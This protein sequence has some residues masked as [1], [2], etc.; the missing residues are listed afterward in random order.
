[1]DLLATKKDRNA[2]IGK[3]FARNFRA[4]N[5]IE[6]RSPGSYV[7]IRDFE[8]VHA[9]ALPYAVLRKT[10]MRDIG[11]TFVENRYPRKAVRVL[12]GSVGSD[13]NGDGVR[14]LPYNR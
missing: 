1:M 7:S 2:A 9:Y 5:I 12:E 3:G 10:D 13:G 8:K 11:I 6:Y 14:N 4:V